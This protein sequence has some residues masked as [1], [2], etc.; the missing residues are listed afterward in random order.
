MRVS[1]LV[2]AAKRPDPRAQ[3]AQQIRDNVKKVLEKA[4]PTYNKFFGGDFKAPTYLK[5]EKRK[6]YDWITATLWDQGHHLNN[7]GLFVS[8]IIQVSNGNIQS[9]IP[10][11][12]YGPN[13][14]A[15]GK[16]VRWMSSADAPPQPEELA[17]PKTFFTPNQYPAEKVKIT[18]HD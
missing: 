1:Q 7:V 3:K 16:Q 14:Y 8:F 5:I 12:K 10:E 18:K 2:R 17:N 9:I 15:H 6:G 13:T 4:V 11:I